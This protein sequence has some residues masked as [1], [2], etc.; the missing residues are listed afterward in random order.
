MF[1][2]MNHSLIYESQVRKTPLAMYVIF[3]SCRLEA[4]CLKNKTIECVTV[5]RLR[6]RPTRDR[7]E[8]DTINA[9]TQV[10]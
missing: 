2:D 1:I 4:V 10:Q 9:R 6:D 3:D 5:S 8:T 7:H